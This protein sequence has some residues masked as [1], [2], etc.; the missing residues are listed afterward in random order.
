M[1]WLDRFRRRSSED[2]LLVRMDS[3]ETWWVRRNPAGEWLET[4]TVE[5][6]EAGERP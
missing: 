2:I 5:A 6:T 4:G 3:G 1:S